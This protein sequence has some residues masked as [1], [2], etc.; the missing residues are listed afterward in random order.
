MTET[1][2]LTC[3]ACTA[4][5]MRPPGVLQGE[6]LPCH[7]CGAELEVTRLDPMEAHQAAEV[8]EDWSE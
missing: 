2:T 3:P 7:D 4:D 5:L 8:G 1:M 6:I